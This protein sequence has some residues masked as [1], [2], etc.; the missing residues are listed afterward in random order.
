MP[1]TPV[2]GMLFRY[3]SRPIYAYSEPYRQI[4]AYLELWLIQASNFSRIFRHIHKVTFLIT[5]NEEYLPRFGHISVDS[6]IFRILALP[7][8]IM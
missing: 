3:Y 5:L 7:V 8:Q 4:Q 6:G 2:S 1:L